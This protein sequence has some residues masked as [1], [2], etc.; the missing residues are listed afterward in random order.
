MRDHLF[1]SSMDFLEVRTFLRGTLLFSL[2]LEE[3]FRLVAGEEGT[4]IL[5][6]LND[7]VDKDCCSYRVKK[8][9]ILVWS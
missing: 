2:D 6:S 8:K 3:I 9:H 5:V 4:G 1:F 7:D